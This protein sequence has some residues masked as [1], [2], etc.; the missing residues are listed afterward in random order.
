MKRARLHWTVATIAIS[1]LITACGEAD[2]NKAA[3]DPEK[4]ASVEP[5]TEPLEPGDLEAPPPVTV[6]FFDRS[7]DL[8]AWTYC[9]GNGCADGS[10][11]AN[12][13]DVGD[14]DEIVIE[15]PL[16]G[17]SFEASFTPTGEKC[18]REQTVPL[19]A[20]GEG[21]FVLRPAG[22]ADT[23]DVTLFGRGDGD[24][25]TTFRWTTPSSG[26][27]PSPEARLAVLA[28]NDGAVD[29]Y[30]VE[31]ELRNLATT[32]SQAS[33]TITVES[34]DGDAISFKAK[35]AG[36]RCLPEGT[37]YWDGPDNEGLAATDLANGPFTYKVEL[38]LDGKRYVAR[39]MWPDDEIVGNEPS[40]RLD[41]TPSL[42]AL[43]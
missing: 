3:A 39:A 34:R 30:G 6:R 31:L 25:F 2:P 43:S 9:Y 14:P 35:R 11:P 21:H 40:V 36:T 13:P 20:K 22:Y 38:M 28:D 18:G 41:F 12:P 10:P 27:L 42:P 1:I 16:S 29:S 4:S 15:F 7:I 32:P 5:S 37:V 8:H 17:W 26:P 33:A 24:L 19:E 23:Y